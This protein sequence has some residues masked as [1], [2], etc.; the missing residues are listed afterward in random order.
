MGRPVDQAAAPRADESA[1]T[2]SPDA[3]AEDEAGS[4]D[5][6]SELYS[7]TREAGMS[8]IAFSLPD[9]DGSD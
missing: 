6:E 9:D 2:S 1:D 8:A 7:S 5:I 3:V 4:E